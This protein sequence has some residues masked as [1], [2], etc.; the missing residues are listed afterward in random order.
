MVLVDVPTCLFAA[1]RLFSPRWGLASAA[2]AALHLVLLRIVG[3]FPASQQAEGGCL[4]CFSP[5]WI[6]DFPA[7]RHQPKNRPR[8]DM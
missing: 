7:S 8:K 1:G 6:T 3:D 4:Y 2:R 5:S